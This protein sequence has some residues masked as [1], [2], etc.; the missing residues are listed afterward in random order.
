[1]GV[2]ARDTPV[3]R[4]SRGTPR[5]LV[6]RRTL[7]GDRHPDRPIPTSRGYGRLSLRRPRRVRRLGHISDQRAAGH[8]GLRQRTRRET[9]LGPGRARVT[10]EFD[11]HSRR[12]ARERR[13]P[14]GRPGAWGVTGGGWLPLPDRRTPTPVRPVP[15]DERTP[16][17]LVRR[18]PQWLHGVEAREAWPAGSHELGHYHTR[19]SLIPSLTRAC[20]RE[21]RP[22][23]PLNQ[24]RVTP[25]PGG[26]RKRGARPNALKQPGDCCRFRVPTAG[27]AGRD[28]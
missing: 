27:I 5:R 2:L 18:L 25:V 6:L 15:A 17:A 13:G 28:R 9:R 19:R 22:V 3:T 8:V 21:R 11:C 24:P 23:F 16:V 20:R 14:H 10:P 12:I 7:D 1:M 4:R 26:L